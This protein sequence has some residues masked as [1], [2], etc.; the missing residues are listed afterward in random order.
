MHFILIFVWF[1]MSTTEFCDH[2]TWILLTS[3]SEQPFAKDRRDYVRA[4]LM[5]I[6]LTSLPFLSC[7]ILLQHLLPYNKCIRA[8]M[9]SVIQ[10]FL[11]LMLLHNIRFSRF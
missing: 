1:K 6:H 11:L 10:F 7:K 9:L 2:Y 4:L 3:K 5:I 8:G